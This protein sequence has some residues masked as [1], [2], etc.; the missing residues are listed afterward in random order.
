MF[1]RTRLAACLLSTAAL[2]GPIIP[3]ASAQAD[4]NQCAPLTID[5]QEAACLAL[6]STP[7]TDPDGNPGL[8]VTF[9]VQVL[10]VQPVTRTQDFFVPLTT[11]EGLPAVIE[12]LPAQVE[13]EIEAEVAAEEQTVCPQGRLAQPWFTGGPGYS[14]SFIY[15]FGSND[16]YTC[17][18]EA[19]LAI[20]AVPPASVTPPGVSTTPHVVNVPY[21]VPQVCVTTSP[22][23]CIGPYDGTLSESVPVPSVS[24]PPSASLGAPTQICI[25]T[26]PTS[27]P[28]TPPFEVPV[29]PRSDGAYD[30]GYY[31][32]SACLPY[33]PVGV[34]YL[35]I[36]PQ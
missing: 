16:S 9:T 13:S 27:S 7:E 36:P 20:S 35:P 3:A 33:I 5:G 34:P 1:H 22:G 28:G 30:I 8:Q 12:G 18:G 23:M 31:D 32:D 4:V 24:S 15:G 10:G 26:G 6:S 2:L 25:L 11:I 21:H 19:G 29:K 17:F 14:P